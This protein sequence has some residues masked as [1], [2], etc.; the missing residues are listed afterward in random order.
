MH[1]DDLVMEKLRDLPLDK[2][3]EVLDFVESLRRR[4]QD[5]AARPVRLRGLCADL[6]VSITEQ[7][8]AVAREEMWAGFARGDV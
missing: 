6:G 1:I 8:I 5:G 3:R 4:A 7:D 2:K